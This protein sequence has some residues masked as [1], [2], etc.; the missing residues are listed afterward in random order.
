MMNLKTSILEDIKAKDNIIKLFLKISFILI[1]SVN[2][3]CNDNSSR[4]TS[5]ETQEVFDI[6]KGLVINFNF[7]TN[8]SDVFTI[9]MQNIQV[10]GLQKKS[11][12]IFEN[13]VPSTNDDAIIAKFDPEN[14]SKDL[15]I[16]LGDK[17]EKFVE[18]KSILISYGNN[19]INL[20]T[21]AD[22]NKHLVFNRFIKRDSLS[23][24]LSTKRI[25]GRLNPTIRVKRSAI[26]LLQKKKSI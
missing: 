21:P 25:D 17:E 20:T 22:L 24:K 13:V 3:S 15:L 7:K 26:N 8:K 6:P 18:I 10:D 16:N 2:L 4:E 19:Q 11:I 14:F 12:E 9:S 23:N 5:N 1:I